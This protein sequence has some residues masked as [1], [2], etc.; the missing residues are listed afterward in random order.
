MD[1]KA[2][3][4][5][6]SRMT[7]MVKGTGSVKRA[8][9]AVTAACMVA[10]CADRASPVMS[11]VGVPTSDVYSISVVAST[12]KNLPKCASSLYG[13]T[14][15]VQSP[16]GL[17]SCQGGIWIPIPCTNILAGA[18]AYSSASRTLLA[19]VSGQWTNVPLPQ[20]PPGANGATGATGAVGP[21]GPQ[22]STGPAGEP[23]KPGSQI[24]ITTEPPGSNCQAGGERIDIGVFGEGGF[25]VQ[26][27]AFVCNG[28]P[29]S[30][31]DAAGVPGGDGG[32]A[33]AAGVKDAAAPD[34][35]VTPDADAGG[36]S[37]DAGGDA[38]GGIP[39]LACYDATAAR[40]TPFGGEA[41]GFDAFASSM[42]ALYANGF[43]AAV[44]PNYFAGG[45]QMLP[46]GVSA[47]CGECLEVTGPN[48]TAVFIVTD[49]DPMPF[50]SPF[51][52]LDAAQSPS[53]IPDGVSGV[54]V[55]P[56]ACPFDDTLKLFVEPGSSSF[57]V[58]LTPFA[59][60]LGVRSLEMRG[61]GA[62]V[63]GDN[64]W[65]TLARTTA[66]AF[67]AAPAQDPRSGGTGIE[68]RIT[69]SEEEVLVPGVVFPLTGGLV[70]DLGTQFQLAPRP[71]PICDWLE[72][73]NVFVDGLGGV[74]G[75]FDPLWQIGGTSLSE[76]I[77]SSNLPA[78]VSES[79]DAVLGAFTGPIF[80]HPFGVDRRSGGTL[81]FWA[82]STVGGG[83]LMP[84]ASGTGF[85]CPL[86]K[87]SLASTW[88][89]FNVPIGC[90]PVANI[91][92]VFFQNDSSAR[93]IPIERSTTIVTIVVRAITSPN[94][95]NLRLRKP[96]TVDR[97]TFRLPS[98]NRGRIVAYAPKMGTTPKKNRKN[99]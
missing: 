19:C 89:L 97:V 45:S 58:S 82:L 73:R 35:A 93:R 81:S 43:R 12:V 51:I 26:Q 64:P 24:Q 86:E 14:A 88:T 21:Q 75:D 49:Q 16:V 92:Q 30:T 85:T 7:G 5:W 46:L 56:V 70:V 59:G 90:T 65:V 72:P 77:D 28:I 57:F 17:Y 69:S 40:Y 67:Q 87:V 33:D 79:I 25:V 50:S 47:G 13:T 55:R 91:T 95:A 54:S 34:V 62:G 10:A 76:T 68:V 23:G 53:I 8:A 42:P 36:S 3:R 22:G 4:M 39:P 1:A 98:R 6:P 52:D 15:Y 27:T 48:G 41:C 99:M 2:N 32:S 66:N 44:D 38:G 74:N 9:W 80:F 31:P 60:R 83:N 94:G 71:A 18:V 20:G 84:I 29:G 61:A 11:S 37:A 96:T 78:A 63:S